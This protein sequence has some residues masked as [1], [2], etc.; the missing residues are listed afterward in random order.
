MVEMLV[1]ISLLFGLLAHKLVWEV[2]KRQAVSV[3]T[4]R[5]DRP[6]SSS[7]RIVKAGKVGLLV[8][9]VIQT[10]FL[11]LFPIADEPPLFRVVGSVLF[12]LGLAT[13]MTGRWQ[14]GENWVDLED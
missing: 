10:L 1:R 3:E 14:L 12:V 11:D 5:P 9:L 4:H 2:L 6:S 8:F 7:L 13:A